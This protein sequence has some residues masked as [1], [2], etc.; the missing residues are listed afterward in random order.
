[1]RAYNF[2]DKIQRST[3]IEGSATQISRQE[4]GCLQK[5]ENS[6]RGICKKRNSR[7][8]KKGPA[9]GVGTGAS[10]C[11]TPGVKFWPLAEPGRNFQSHLRIE[12]RGSP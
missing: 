1:M 6:R 4:A 3:L 8:T 12:R 11:C 9:I 7:L 5:S 2:E 10:S